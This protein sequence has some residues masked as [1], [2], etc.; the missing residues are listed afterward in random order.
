MILDGA[1]RTARRGRRELLG[2]VGLGER[3]DHR[4][5]RLSGGEQQRVAIAVALANEPDG[6]CSPTSRPA[7]STAATVARDLRAAPAGQRASSGRRS[8]IVTHDALVSEQVQRTVAIRDGRTSTETLRRTELTDDG[9][10][11]ASSP[12]SSRSS[13]G[14]AGCS[15]R[16]RTSRRSGCSDRVRLRL[17]D[18][19]VEVWPDAEPAPADGSA[20]PA[21]TPVDGRRPADRPTPPTAPAAADAPPTARPSPLVEARRPRPRL[22]VGRRV[23]HAL[24]GVDLRGRAGRARRRP[25][26]VG[27]RQDDAAQPARRAR[28]AD[29]RAGSSS[30]ARRSRRCARASSSTSAGGT[31]AFIFQAFGLL[32]IL[33]AAENVEVPLRLVRAEPARAR[34]AGARAAGAGR[35]RRPGEAP[36]A[37]AVGRRAAARG[38]RPGARQPAAAAARRRADRPA[39]LRDR[40]RDHA[41]AP[42]RSSGT[43][44]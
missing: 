27:Q 16:A 14:P 17:E 38:D 35:A 28:P 19:H 5:E 31:V 2:L 34:R 6:R 41:A 44:A 37:R 13:T 39:R 24:R 36:A 26:P 30:T 7:S 9:R 22:P 32:P 42:R 23:V 25:R 1:A 10:A 8:S 40:P 4:P 33:S 18:D 3:A 29:V 43:R 11:T 21:T 15:C 20:R 12:R